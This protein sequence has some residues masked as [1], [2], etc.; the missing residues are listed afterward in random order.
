MNKAIC[1]WVMASAFF[2]VV[3]AHG[4][5]DNPTVDSS[6][7]PSGQVV[8]ADGFVALDTTQ[9]STV[10]GKR[11]LISAYGSLFSILLVY[12]FSLYRRERAVARAAAKLEKRLQSR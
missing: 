7:T 10:S 6:D 1:F 8:D 3:P 4:A 11:L 12:A 9:L 5:P 2:G